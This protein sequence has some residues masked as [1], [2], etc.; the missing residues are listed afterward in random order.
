MFTL[1]QA[2]KALEGRQEFVIKE[3]EDTI[4]FDYVVI[5][6]DTFSDPH[7]G[8]IRKNFRGVTFCKFTG[9]LLS[10]PFPKFFNINQTAES[11]FLL[12]K[13]KKATIYEKVDGSLIHFYR[14]KNI[15]LVASTCRSPESLQAK[16]ALD[17]LNNNQRLLHYVLDSIDAGLTPIFEWCA[18]HNQIVLHYKEPRLIYLMSRF[19]DN[20]TYLFESKF[21]DKAQRFEIPF[22]EILKNVNKTE[23]EGYVCYLEDGNVFKV[24]TPWYLE[25]H[26]SV[27]LL[28]RP[29]YKS[30]EISLDG[31]MDDVIALSPEGHKTIFRE[32]DNE[33]K[34]DILETKLSIEKEFEEL[35]KKLDNDCMEDYRKRFAMAA[36]ESQNFPALMQILSGKSPDSL[37]KKKLLEKYCEKYPTRIMK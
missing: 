7:Y 27:D 1:N 37:I 6:D 25:R 2:F 13:N 28:T 16:E 30:Y 3:L 33:V 12:H 10:L 22:Y 21:E 4:A 24:K 19:R 20:G 32:I 8:W 15:K 31:Y 36:K 23:F 18:P 17:F 14:K 26:K 11:Q 35:T 29:K 34:N 9:K 5:K